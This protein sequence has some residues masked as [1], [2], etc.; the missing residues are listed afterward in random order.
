MTNRIGTTAAFTLYRSHM[1]SLQK[2]INDLSYQS[3][4]GERYSSYDRYGLTSY[5]LVTLENE[6]KIVEQY[7]ENNEITKVNLETMESSVDSIR[8]ILLEFQSSLTA[9]YAN[10]LQNMDT[11]EGITQIANLQEA[12]YEAMSQVAYFLNAQVDGVYVFGGGENT[13]PPVDFPFKSLEDFQAYYDGNT[14]TYPSDIR[15]LLSNIETSDGVTGGLTFKQNM[16][17]ADTSLRRP[18][19]F[20]ATK[21]EDGTIS[22][23]LTAA[24]GIFTGLAAGDTLTIAGTA[25]NNGAFQIASVSADGSTV[26]FVD[27]AAISEEVVAAD[28]AVANVAITAPAGN[29]NMTTATSSAYAFEMQTN[30]DGTQSA[31]L[32][33][34]PDAFSNLQS[35]D[36]IRITGTGANDGVYY[37]KSVSLDGTKITFGDGVTVN[38]EII[39]A[40]TA[41]LNDI[42]IE[43][44]DVTGT[45]DAM[46]SDGYSLADWTIP[47]AELTLNEADQ[48]LTASHMHYFENITLGQ[49]VKIGGK[50][51]YVKN[52]EFDEAADTAKITLSRDTPLTAADIPA[53]NV[54][55]SSLSDVHGFV[56]DVIKGSEALTGDIFFNAAK[57]QMTANVTGAFEGVQAGDTI[58]L[59]GADGNNGVYYVK[60]VGADGRTITFSDETK[61]NVDGKIENGTG[62]SLGLTYPVGSTLAVDKVSAS[63]N[64]S[65]TILGIS[66]D[67]NSLTVKT[68]RFTKDGASF[69]A[70][71]MQSVKTSSY[72]QGSSLQSTVRVGTQ[73]EIKMDIDASKGAFATIFTALGQIAQGN[74]IDLRDEEQT[75]DAIDPNR[76][77]TRVRASLDLITEALSSYRTADSYSN[78]TNIQYALVSKSSRLQNTTTAQTNLSASLETY[79]GNIKRVDQTEA[80]TMLLEEKKNLSASYQVFSTINNLS[81]LNYL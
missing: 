23:T 56:S 48:T 66:A 30:E 12:A 7:L 79:I 55:F 59:K 19:Q 62:V 18:L 42:V 35:G 54:D 45:I 17:Q 27:G 10:D 15:A 68:N 37:V 43:Q 11:Q 65:Y 26:T 2:K 36:E 49:S 34:G 21:N 25:H 77:E 33:G 32:K 70:T 51:V 47:S 53:G 71:G 1:S 64:G 81:L 76:V 57:N 72:Y 16:V 39:N 52:V 41:N 9:F 22:R 6:Q 50:T 5:R 13:K 67:G 4:T 61:L 78:I 44:K 8:K 38:P 80:V 28:D 69:A 46:N 73:T 14:L 58:V 75:L 20:R 74:L 31:V 29:I 63:Y 24:A 3:V 60:D 40:D